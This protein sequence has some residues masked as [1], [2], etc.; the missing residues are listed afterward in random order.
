MAPGLMLANE[1]AQLERDDAQP[2]RNHAGLHED[3][4]LIRLGPADLS[5]ATSPARPASHT[6]RPSI[7]S[8]KRPACSDPPGRRVSLRWST[9]PAPE[10][11]PNRPEPTAAA[12]DGWVLDLQVRS[13]GSRTPA[14]R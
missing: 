7:T 4:Q 9:W 10:P 5:C 1:Q 12:T 14:A 3:D 2:Q 13:A 8:A 11:T 6:L